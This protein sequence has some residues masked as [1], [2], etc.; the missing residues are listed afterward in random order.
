MAPVDLPAL[1]ARVAER[2][3][4]PDQ[5]I[6]LTYASAIHSV[7]AREMDLETALLNLLDNAVRFSPPGQPVEVDVTGAPGAVRIAIRDHGPG[8]SEA[9]MPKIFDRF[10]T[11]DADRD[12][13]GL[14]LAIVETVIE[15]HGGT[16]R[17]ESPPGQGATFTV[18][19]PVK[20]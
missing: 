19:L 6:N 1:L 17:A 9:V 20:R 13:T 5:P 14:G 12:G 10:F 18:T 3:G 15:A 2:A 16:V 7:P 11:T 4:S 8:I